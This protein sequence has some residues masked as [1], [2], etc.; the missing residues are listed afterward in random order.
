MIKF[1]ETQVFGFEGA[2]RG[3]RN[4]KNSWDKSDSEYKMYPYEDEYRVGDNDL[5]LMKRLVN[6]GTDHSKFMRMIGVWTD[7]TAPQYWWHEFDTYKVGTVR[8]SCS[9]MHTI[10]IKP[11]TYDDFTHEGIDEVGQPYKEHFQI[12][13]DTLEKLRKRF[14]DTQDKK[15]WRA[16]IEML[17]ESYN[18]RATVMLNYQVLRT[19][20]HARKN[21]KLSEWH[22]F[23]DWIKLL[24]YSE[25][26][27]GEK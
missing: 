8:N 3:M 7:I 20:Y 26:I 23:C 24:P 13:V 25:L 18:M 17:P 11:F 14:D 1:D 15:Y 9:K 4:P 16:I 12:Y 19:M 27:T 5:T 21:H 22:T 10:H 6:A 2:I